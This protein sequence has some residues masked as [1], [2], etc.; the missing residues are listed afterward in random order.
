VPT[1]PGVTNPPGATAG[2]TAGAPTQ[3]PAGTPIPQP[4]GGDLEAKVR[5]LVPPG[6]TEVTA[7]AVGGSFS[8]TVNNP[9]PLDQLEAFWDQKIPTAGV[10]QTGKVEA[11]GTLT[12]GFTDPDGGI[13]AAPNGSGGFVITISLGIT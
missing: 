12:Y 11:G 9:G 3:P 1:V 13:V 6:S 2:T 8:V 10:T 7:A 5:S 4:N